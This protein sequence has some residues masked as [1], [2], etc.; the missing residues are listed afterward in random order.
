MANE[1]ENTETPKTSEKTTAV[2]LDERLRDAHEDGAE[3]G[4]GD[5]VDVIAL[6]LRRMPHTMVLAL[7]GF[8]AGF[9]LERGLMSPWD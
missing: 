4:A 7:A 5:H 3:L 9:D 8:G 1:R 2:L 6:V